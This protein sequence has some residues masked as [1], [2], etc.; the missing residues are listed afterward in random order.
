MLLNAVM[1][2]SNGLAVVGVGE[3][4]PSE[5]QLGAVSLKGEVDGG[6]GAPVA[7]TDDVVV[8][9]VGLDV[10]VVT[11]VVVTAVVTG[12]T[13]VLVVTVVLAPFVVVVTIVV[14]VTPVGTVTP[15]VVA[16]AAVVVVP[17]GLVAGDVLVGEVLMALSADV[18][19][20]LSADVVA[21][22]DGADDAVADG[23]VSCRSDVTAVVDEVVV[24]TAVVTDP[25][26]VP[27][28][29]MVLAAVVA[30]LVTAV[31]AVVAGTAVVVAAII[32]AVVGGE[33]LVVGLLVV[34]TADVPVGDGTEDVLADG[35]IFCGS[36][37]LVVVDEAVTVAVS[38]VGSPIESRPE[39]PDTPERV[40]AASSAIVSGSTRVKLTVAKPSS[41]TT[42]LP[43]VQSPG[44]G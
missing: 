17:A 30:V 1:V 6:R 15:D 38:P 26:E 4:G 5:N 3:D 25:I 32:V 12:P 20:V 2:I 36:D 37:V 11:A 23:V 24:L 34:T 21:V 22:G 10:V 35:V 7:G 19:V 33:G 9:M 8:V 43:S 29:D 31:T 28:E 27:G 18:V 39:T 14:L 13:E 42:A 44:G 41:N 16:V 40:S